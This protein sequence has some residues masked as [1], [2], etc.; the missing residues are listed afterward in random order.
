MYSHTYDWKFQ[1]QISKMR[2]RF[3][4]VCGIQCPTQPCQH[5]EA[6]TRFKGSPHEAQPLQSIRIEQAVAACGA[7][8]QPQQ[9]TQHI[10]AHDMHAH[11]GIMGQ[12]GHRVGIHR[13]P[14]FGWF[15]AMH[16]PFR[17]VQSAPRVRCRRRGTLGRY[18]ITVFSM[19]WFATDVD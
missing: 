3:I 17:R 4:A 2:H 9:P 7:F 1:A 6:D 5:V 15:A 11:A 10:V 13:T 16:V 8:H 12:T 14:P 18:P 19:E